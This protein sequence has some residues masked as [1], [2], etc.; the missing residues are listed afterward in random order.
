MFELNNYNNKNVNTKAYFSH[1]R[2]PADS[3]EMSMIGEPTNDSIDA[4]LS[5][6]P[7]VLHKFLTPKSRN[8]TAAAHSKL[9]INLLIE[10]IFS[11]F[12]F[13]SIHSAAQ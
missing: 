9:A 1:F 6:V 13:F 8:Q 5:M 2:S 3:R 12:S 7:S 4:M 11:L 10:R